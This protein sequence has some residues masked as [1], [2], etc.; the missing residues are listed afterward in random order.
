MRYYNKQT[1]I[2]TDWS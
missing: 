1:R 2:V